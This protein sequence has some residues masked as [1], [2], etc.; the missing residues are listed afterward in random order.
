[1]KPVLT[2]K[3]QKLTGVGSLG[4]RGDRAKGRDESTTL[5]LFLGL[6]A[7]HGMVLFLEMT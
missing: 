5:G 4:E 7:R 6:P 2:R 3:A 1:M